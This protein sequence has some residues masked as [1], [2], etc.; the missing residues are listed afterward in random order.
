[1]SRIKEEILNRINE[2]GYGAFTSSDFIDIGN[3]KSISK[4]LE[5]LEDEKIIKRIKRGVYYLPKFNELLGIEELQILIKSPKL[6][7]GD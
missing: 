7:Q 6:L 1:M 3:Y 2:K 4:A 5:T